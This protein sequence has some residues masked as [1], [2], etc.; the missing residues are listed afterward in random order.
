MGTLSGQPTRLPS[1][2]RSCAMADDRTG[3]SADA[4]VVLVHG[5]GSSFEHGWRGAGWID[6]I[7]EAGRTVVPVDILGH[8]TAARPHDPAAYAELE[9]SVGRVL[10]DVPVDAIGFSLG[11]QLLLRLAA[12]DPRRFRRLVVIGAGANVFRTD[13]TE[14]LAS[15]F[16]RSS[17]ERKGG[18]EEIAARVFV[19]LAAEAGNDP[20]HDGRVSPAPAATVD[21]RGSRAGDVP[22]ARHPRRQGLCRTA[23]TAARR[24]SRRCGS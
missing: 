2:L 3:D 10:P 23:G 19:S 24:A 7:G 13:S 16:E 6:L 5:L 15:A 12:S 21:R 18:D 9:Q 8:G 4:P 17:G 1:R 22:G 14:G 20:L 11:A